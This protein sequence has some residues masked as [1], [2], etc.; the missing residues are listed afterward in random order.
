[1]RKLYRIVNWI[2]LIALLTV[3]VGPT[4]VCAQDDPDKFIAALIEQMSPQ[5]KVGQLFV[6]AFAGAD[7]SANSDIARLIREY[8]VGGVVLSPEA[9]N[10]I[11][12]GN[13]PV[14]VATLTAALQN[15][16]RAAAQTVNPV[17]GKTTPFIP[18]FIALPYETDAATRVNGMTPLPSPLML[19][20]TW[21]RQD[22]QAAG[23]LL[24]QELAAMGVNVIL[25]PSFDIASSAW[26]NQM[27]GGDPYWVS[28]IGQAFV[29]GVRE[30][31]ANRMVTALAHFPG[32]GEAPG[33]D[34]AIDKSLEELEKL[35]LL[36]FLE[37]IALPGGE[38]R[39]LADALL[40]TQMRY[41]GFSGNYR[42]RT[43]PLAVDAQAMQLLLAI[44]Q[45]KAWRDSGQGVLF[46]GSLGSPAL[47]Q[48][49]ASLAVPPQ[50]IAQDAFQAGNDILILSNFGGDSW[51]EQ[52]NAIT[53]T[54]TFFQNKYS[55]DLA[56]QTR[57]NDA[58]PRILRL[59][60]RLYPR[61]DPATVMVNPAA[62]TTLVGLGQEVAT[63]VAQNA[64]T[65]LWPPTAQPLPPD[66]Q[67][68]LVIITDD[69]QVRD[70]P[71]CRPRQLIDTDALANAIVQGYGASGRIDPTR[72]SSLRFGDVQ[73]YLDGIQREGA[74]D[75]GAIL[76]NANV[77]VLA[78]VD[79]QLE[80]AAQLMRRLLVTSP[81][82]LG[83]K[84]V[85]AFSFG[86]PQALERDEINRVAAYYCLYTSSTPSIQVAAQILFGD[87]PAPGALPVSLPAIGYDLTRQL[88]ADPNQM[89]QILVGEASA[90]D[91][92]TPQPVE[93]KVGDKLTV[94]AG[95]ILD[96]NGHTVPDG[97]QVT[98][99][100]LFSDNIELPPIT[101]STV[102]G[103]ARTEIVL[104]KVGLLRIRAFSEPA[105]T[106][107]ELQV[108]SL[109]NQQVTIT[110]VAPPTRTPVPVIPTST[111]TPRPTATPT[112]TPTPVPP[113]WAPLTQ[114]AAPRRVY[115]GDLFLALGGIAVVGLFVYRLT[116]MV[117]RANHQPNGQIVAARWAL[118]CV[119]AGL[120]GYVLYG[121]GLPGVNQLD[122]IGSAWAALIVSVV[123]ALMPLVVAWGWREATR[124][125]SWPL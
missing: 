54:I 57:V 47:R 9:G 42:E 52:L 18:L 58:L 116:L 117:E 70:C 113:W 79:G 75:V 55:T 76:G 34:G 65:R 19:G 107:Y 46:S 8:Y 27:F 82:A 13:T 11:N 120:T 122:S 12:S 81:E 37:A 33:S 93:V 39:P 48:Y 7:A 28:V 69:R 86:D 1:M 84:Q 51:Q 111:P 101:A 109:E 56:F 87:L 96:R 100:R 43:R 106:S 59:K 104:D 98:F 80:S 78:L 31:S 22:A 25:G 41:R 102:N 67:S 23:A 125:A 2:I 123:S 24:G 64:A 16:A 21:S 103:I 77:I 63:Q 15:Q 118:W 110:A 3:L 97:T 32:Q 4:V 35:D 6:V 94:R 45:V 91:Q 112:P 49:Y 114:P 68:A 60:Y 29:Q 72:V 92:A 50:R 124:R 115:W 95:P 105:L 14:Q 88:E 62:V 17:T 36:P 66:P 83:D 90:G 44:P 5:A 38:G 61:F 73:D 85:I 121:L 74:P 71:T 99:T 89:I 53:T 119:M 40:V 10:I 108:T 20:A 30:G 26:N